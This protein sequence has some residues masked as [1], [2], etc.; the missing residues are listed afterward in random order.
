MS[1]RPGPRSDVDV[2]L[3]A[4][5]VAERLFGSQGAGAVSLRAVAREAG[6][7]TAGLTYH[8]PTRRALVSAVVRRRARVLGPQIRLNL[9]ELVSSPHAPDPYDVVQAVLRPLADL[10]HTDT[11][12]G[13]HWLKVFAQVW[14]AEDHVWHGEMATAGDLPVLFLQAAARA[15][16]DIDS[17]PTQARLSIALLSM[18]TTLASADLPGYDGLGEAGLDPLFVA[19][20]ASFTAAG[21]AAAGRG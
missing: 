7:S 10:V 15:L 21:M 2:K 14:L 4:V 6:V 19:E 5:E 18:L 8:F 13:L 16:P 3:R 20:L 17:P 11:E 12:G 9:A 1:N